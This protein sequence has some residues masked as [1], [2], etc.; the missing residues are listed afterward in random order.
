MNCSFISLVFTTQ[1][2][3]DCYTNPK[4]YQDVNVVFLKC[5][6]NNEL[7][8]VFLSWQFYFL[9]KQKFYHPTSSFGFLPKFILAYVTKK[10]FD[11][12]RC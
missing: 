2:N 11:L 9:P 5:H 7:D 12:M 4:E 1:C 10:T 6:G 8:F 3:E